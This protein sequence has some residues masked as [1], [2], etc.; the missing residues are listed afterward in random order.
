MTHCPTQAI[1]SREN[2][3]LRRSIRLPK[4]DYAQPRAYFVTICTQNQLPILGRIV[5]GEIVLSQEANIIM[6]CLERIPHHFKN[7][8]L[9]TYT[10]MPTHI[11]AII[12]LKDR[13]GEASGKDGSILAL[14]P[15]ADASP[16]HQNDSRPRSTKK[17]S[18]G[19]ILQNFKSVSTR[20]INQV[21][22]T[23]R[24]R[25]WQRNYFEHIIRTERSLNAIHQ[26]V[27]TNPV[28][29]DL[30]RNNPKGSGIDKEAKDFWNLMGKDV[31]LKKV[32]M[33]K[34]QD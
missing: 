9:D 19:A 29:W 14:E 11:H 31:I 21:H 18:L 7:S 24:K 23:P 3:V 22:N 5:D 17:G 15:K 8:T 28:R 32:E 6:K 4:Y 1:D 20:K 33:Q 2:N 34:W 12:V 13:R 25:T 16:L 30:D 10:I 26:Y 27:M